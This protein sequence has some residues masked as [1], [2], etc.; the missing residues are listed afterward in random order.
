MIGFI[1]GIACFCLGYYVS[2]VCHNAYLK[3]VWKRYK[4]IYQGSCS[5]DEIP[6]IKGQ[7]EYSDGW[8]DALDHIIK[9]WRSK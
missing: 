6:Y 4:I 9:K 7:D 1:I 2:A 3:G 8:N 5:E